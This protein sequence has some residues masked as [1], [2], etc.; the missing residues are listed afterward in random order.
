LRLM[1]RHAAA[2]EQRQAIVARLADIG[3]DLYVMTAVCGYAEIVAD[4]AA[5]ALQAC[6]DA[7]E[8]IEDR[9][10]SLSSN[11]D[12]ETSA[13]GRQALDGA[14]DWLTEGSMERMD[15]LPELIGADL[16]AAPGP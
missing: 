10:R 14:F 3:I 16:V 11:R 5:L 2:L 1:A 15:L 4:G 8:R 7:R 13:I 9:F 6:A 12:A